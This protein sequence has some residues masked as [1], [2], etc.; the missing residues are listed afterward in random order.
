MHQGPAHYWHALSALFG[1]IVHSQRHGFGEWMQPTHSLLFTNTQPIDWQVPAALKLLQQ[2]LQS[3]EELFE[4]D[5][6]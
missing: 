2:R 1:A 3:M 4:V 6:P 5:A